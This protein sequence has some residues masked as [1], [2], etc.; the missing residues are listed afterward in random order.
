MA[1]FMVK[2]NEHI[3]ELTRKNAA[4]EHAVSEEPEKI[5]KDIEPSTIAAAE[6][7]NSAPLA[8]MGEIFNIF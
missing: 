1:K 2:L 8:E 5:A 7:A 3:L 4:I 6:Y